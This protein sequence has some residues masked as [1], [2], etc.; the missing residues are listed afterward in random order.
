[1]TSVLAPSDTARPEDQTDPGPPARAQFSFPDAAPAP[2]LAT[3]PAV[4]DLF[5]GAGGLSHGLAMAGLHPAGAVEIHPHAALTYQRNHPGSPVLVKDVR[6]ASANE[7][8]GMVKSVSE[9]V[10]RSGRIDC[11]VGG[12]PCQGFSFAGSKEQ[13][14]L[15]NTLPFDFVRLVQQLQPSMFVLEN[16]YGLVKLYKGEVFRKLMEELADLPGYRVTH[17]VVS[18]EDFGVPSMRRRVLIVG[19]SLKK[20]FA[21]PQPT[22]GPLETPSADLNLLPHVTARE[23]LSDLDFLSLPGDSGNHYE[24]LPTSEFQKW[25]R[26]GAV[27]LH[28]H[29]STAHSQRVSDIFSLIPPGHGPDALPPHLRSKKDGLLRIHPDRLCRAI[30]SAPEDLI[31]YNRDRIPTV[32][33][34]ARLQSFPDTFVFM[35]QR[36]SGNQNRKAG[37]CSQ[38]QQVGNSVPP[39]LGFALGKAIRAHLED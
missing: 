2:D 38:T 9:R 27:R 1:M 10:Q 18:A 33:E 11:I 5:A 37:Y 35:G 22:H 8:L 30:L 21:Y 26:Q 17:E 31:H 15:R 25:A 20:P 34:Q 28:N 36:T 24:Q 39:L 29:E 7:L 14:D 23:A 6:S 4:L 12:P 13:T 32:R 16:V 3:A 19:T